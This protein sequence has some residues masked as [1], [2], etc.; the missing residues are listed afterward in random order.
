MRE[1]NKQVALEKSDLE[2]EG[3]VIQLEGSWFEA[4]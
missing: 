1:I 3:V 4:H 2:G